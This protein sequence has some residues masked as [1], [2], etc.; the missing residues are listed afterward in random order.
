MTT[1][2]AAEAE[3][4]ARCRAGDQEAFR[5][6]VETHH[7]R[8]YRTAYAVTADAAEASE[9]AQETFV[10]AWRRLGRF[11]GNASLATWLTRLA[12]NTA[13]DQLCRQR[14][15]DALAVVRGIRFGRFQPH[16]SHAEQAIEDRDEVQRALDRLSPR[17]RQV[18]ALRYGLDLSL[19]EIAQ[20]LDCPEGTVKSR[21]NAALGQLRAIIGQERAAIR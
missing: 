8:V 6:L 1:E 15:R 16:E 20:V 2:G 11:R 21:L 9:V 4:I 12:L 5:R 18:V 17:A 10:K 7:Q 3:L 13:R 14:V 19:K